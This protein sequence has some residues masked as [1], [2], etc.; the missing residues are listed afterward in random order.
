MTD[1]K[2]PISS[3]EDYIDTQLFSS[4]IQFL[5]GDIDSDSVSS[6]I[7]WLI[8]ENL[9]EDTT[10]LTLY[11]NSEGGS[12]QDAFALIDIMK[13]SER[14]VRTI[15]IGSVISA[16]FLI[17]ISGTRGH[18]IISNNASIMCHQFSD[19]YEGKYHDLK[20]IGKE[21]ELA[22]NRMANLISSCC[23]LKPNS[24][25][26]KLLSPTDMWLKADEIIKLG[27]ADRLF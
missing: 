19:Y 24:V 20:S 5:C 26:S 13:K 11:I 12:L 8:F 23:D 14:V 17:F 16:G 1:E 3:F 6:V 27:L 2:T 25:K 9:K 22:N 7:K 21:N 4:G 10:P 18:R 15:G